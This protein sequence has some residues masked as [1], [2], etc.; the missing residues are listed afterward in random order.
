MKK[1][2]LALI[3]ISV[4]FSKNDASAEMSMQEKD[5]SH[6][7]MSLN[8]S[9]WSIEDAA[10][11]TKITSVQPSPDGKY[12]LIESYPPYVD[13][14]KIQP[15]EI[16]L[17]NAETKELVW[18]TPN[19]W[20]CLTAHW[21]PDGKNI[22][23]LRLGDEEKDTYSLI[24][25]PPHKFEPIE[26]AKGTWDIS[27]YF[28]SPDSK[29][30][31]LL[32]GEE[33][34]PEGDEDYLIIGPSK[35]KS[36]LYLLS[37]KFPLK[38]HIEPKLLSFENSSFPKISVKPETM[39]SWSPNNEHIAFV[40]ID[41]AND[42]ERVFN[43][44]VPSGKIALIADKGKPNSP[45][46]SPDG[47]LIAY[48]ADVEERFPEKPFP[49]KKRH[50]FLKA[51]GE[52]TSQKLASTFEEQ[53]TL[54]G[55]FPD[56]QH[57]L[58]YEGY[59]TTKRLYKLPING[60]KPEV[61][62]ANTEDFISTVS[63][64]PSRKDIGFLSESLDRAPVAFI[65]SLENFLPRRMLQAFSQA[66]PIK[67]EVIQWKSFDGKEIEGILIY[68]SFYQTGKTYPLVVAAHDGPYEAW[69]K[70]FMGGCYDNVPFS[71]AVLSAQGYA[72]FLPNIR[73]SSNY[74]LEFARAN[75][76]DLG[77]GDF[78]DLM[79]GVDFLI[80]KGIADPEKLA[81]W[82]W[83]YGGYLAAWAT[84]QTNHFK[85]SIVGAG[86]VN[87]IAFSLTTDT[88]GFL[89]DYLGGPFWKNKDLWLSRSPIMKLQNANTPTLLQY[90]S[91]DKIFPPNRGK[92]WFFALDEK[93]IPTKM[94][95]FTKEGHHFQLY[96]L[97]RKVALTALVEWLDQ[98]L[99]PSSKNKQI[100]QE[101]ID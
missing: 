69:E 37:L 70:R 5:N 17:I 62:N 8:I 61:L 72:V 4:G 90:G 73:G 10:M 25:T 43:I 57:L 92:E 83:G 54:I 7:D 21:V 29:S 42:L 78:K 58:V 93:D 13:D 63:L 60:E 27:D 84:T 16:S 18:K 35:S 97:S 89:E 59:K 86:I 9:S 50:V 33:P 66:I 64:S 67:N 56:G 32:V 38:G 47:K 6:R 28:W 1:I 19:D 82:G 41:P 87:F 2:I 55:W 49:I 31:V 34:I 15:T 14:N 65:S 79:S 95:T 12:L 94:M 22:S 51:V 23:F 71:P 101:H 30:I 91:N 46:Y 45:L 52:Q 77:G 48:V 76:K 44:N 85:A 53:P 68:P 80:E 36:L 11:Q 81:I 26:I 99:Q 20:L 3:F 40:G 39:I 24:I 75:Q 98:Y 88:K 74:G 96:A 100:K